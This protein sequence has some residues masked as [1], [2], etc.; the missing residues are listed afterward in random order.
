[1][2]CIGHGLFRKLVSCAVLG[3]TFR[4]D[5]DF[6]KS[7]PFYFCLIMKK[8]LSLIFLSMIAFNVIHA[9]ITWTLSDDG[10]L[11]ISGADMPNYSSYHG[12]IPWYS[13]RENIKKVVIEDGV[14]NIGN[15][16]FYECTNLNSIT[17]PNSITIIGNSSFYYCI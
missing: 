5:E 6:G 7:A 8:L 2:S 4:K 9:E 11:T 17:I 1:M 15:C 16:A 14:T 3:G 13:Q 12:T 10:T